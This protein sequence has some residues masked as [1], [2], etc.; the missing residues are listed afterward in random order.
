MTR[1]PDLI[2]LIEGYLD[3][4]E[5]HTPLPDATRDAIRARLPSTTQRPAWW[6]GWRFPDMNSITKIGLAVAAVAVAAVLGFNYLA[7]AN[8]GGP[9][10]ADPSPTSTPTAV[11]DPGGP[12][13]YAIGAP[14]P[15]RITLELPDGWQAWASTADVHGLV[16]DNAMGDGSSGWGPAFWIVQNVY[17]DPCAI[18]SRLDPQ[19]GPSVDDLA[20]ALT[21]LP[22]YEATV[23]TPVTVSGF[24]GVEFQLTAPEYGDDC[25]NHRTWSTFTEPRSMYP[26]ETNRIQILDVDGVRLV[27]SIVEYAYTTEFE[28]ELGIP[29]DPN[30]HAADQPELRA[31]LDSMRIESRP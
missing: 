27:L 17:A 28:Q 14:F 4:F 2:G 12:R 29:F 10:P 18:G 30:G 23:P 31:M 1:D 25:P 6:P 19:L 13:P 24:S 3:D 26:G 15:V 9:G 16:V 21:S 22:G 11:A 8:V 20:D 5:G 7:N